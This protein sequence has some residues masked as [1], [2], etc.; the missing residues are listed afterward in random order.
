MKRIVIII[1][2]LICPAFAMT[3]AGIIGDINGDGSLKIT[4]VISLLFLGRDDPQD[5][6]ADFNGDGVYTVS[7]AIALVIYIKNVG[8]QE[9]LEFSDVALTNHTGTAFVVS[10]RTSRPTSDNLVLYGTDR[11]NMDRLM[12]DSTVLEQPSLIHFVQLVFLKPDT[13]Y[14]YRIGSSG[15]EFSVGR[16]GVDSVVTFSQSLSTV[17]LLVEGQVTDQAGQTVEGAL[18]RSFLK[19]DTGTMVD[20]SMW[21]SNLT[22]S[23]GIFWNELANYRNYAG[24]PVMYSPSRTWF[25]LYILGEA[26]KSSRDSVLLTGPQG[27]FQQLGT[28]RL[29]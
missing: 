12:E 25:H 18:V 24:S 10:W 21:F 28:F 4:D 3:R 2:L 23:E 13:T 26:R 7:D 8:G 19:W 6:R 29:P 9:P 1:T 15:L 20:S 17:R 27:S 22:N 5:P 11:N 16:Q 14:Y